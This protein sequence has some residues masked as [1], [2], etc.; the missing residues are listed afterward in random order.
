MSQNGPF[1]EKLWA[2]VNLTISNYVTM[3]YLPSQRRARRLQGGDASSEETERKRET[4]E[5]RGEESD[6]EEM[7]CDMSTAPSLHGTFLFLCHSRL[8][9]WVRMIILKEFHWLWSGLS[10]SFCHMRHAHLCLLY[11]SGFHHFIVEQFVKGETVW[12]NKQPIKC[13]QLGTTETTW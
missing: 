13:F 6:Q 4:K 12:S 2:C 1:S 7:S 9:Y 5:R 11:S 3:F 10:S 8:Y